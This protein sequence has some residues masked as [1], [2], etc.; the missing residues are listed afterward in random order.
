MDLFLIRLL[1]Y[2]TFTQ[3]QFLTDHQPLIP[4]L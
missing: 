1:D 4:K 3:Q 2:L